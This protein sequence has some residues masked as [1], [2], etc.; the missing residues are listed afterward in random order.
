MQLY[1]H[2]LKAYEQM[3]EKFKSS[4]KAAIIHPTGTGKMYI[5]LKWLLDNPQEKFLFLA[6]TSAIMYQ[7]NYTIE[8]N[9]Y[10]ISDFPNLSCALYCQLLNWDKEEFNAKYDNIVLDEFHRAGAPKWGQAIDILL[11]NHSDSKVLGLSA[12]P[13]RYSDHKN[14]VDILFEG[15]VASEITLAEAMARG[16]LPLPIYIST[17]YSLNEQMQELEEKIKTVSNRFQKLELENLMEQAK[18]SLKQIEGLQQI[19]TQYITKKDGKY[20]IFCKDIEHLEEIKRKV[21]EWFGNINGEIEVY[22]VH[23]KH[24][25]L[26]NE[27]TLRCFRQDNSHKL[28]LLLSVEM[29]N[30]GLHVDNI[31]GVIMLRPT[32]SHIVYMQ[33]LGRALSTNN[34]QPLVIDIVN[35]I[36]A[37]ESIYDIREEIEDFIYEHQ[38]QCIQK[39]TLEAQFKI[40]DCVKDVMS[41]LE[42]VDANFRMS[43]QVKLSI[44][45]AY[46]DE[47]HKYSDIVESTVDKHN[48]PIGSWIRNWRHGRAKLTAEERSILISMG[49]TFER[50]YKVALTNQQKLD[51]IKS[52]IDLGHS[53]SSIVKS[54]QD[55][56][57]HDLG[58]WIVHWR[59][60]FTPLTKD[61]REQLMLM[62]ETFKEKRTPQ[63]SNL[64]KL[65]ILQTYINS[66]NSYASITRSTRDN[67]NHPLGVW[68]SNWRS[69]VVALTDEERRQLM[70]LGETFESKKPWKMKIYAPLESLE[71]T[72]LERPTPMP[73]PH[74]SL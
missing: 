6:P 22:D 31:D 58:G 72:I 27:E 10:H 5:F 71:K 25:D 8:E 34:T 69:G 32:A 40:F 11:Q 16:I 63:F 2:N 20:L 17:V 41:I 21:K 29:L 51:I 35:N 53:Y 3:K 62:G 45:Q 57:G 66:G 33:Q 50:K 38:S 36:S 46:L 52:Y 37:Y 14:M 68:I 18:V 70:S 44:I 67:E 4:H 42:T 64:Q 47:G 60:G 59:S 54:T 1:D 7:L 19:F 61:E 73:A 12:T 74:K 39:E 23:S 55:S 43:N 56:E 26:K 49:E 48:Y 30:D 24:S 15:N 9:G 28:K 65:K 13:T